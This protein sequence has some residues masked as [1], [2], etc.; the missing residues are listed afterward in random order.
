MKKQSI[1]RIF[2]LLTILSMLIASQTPAFAAAPGQTTGTT[3]SIHIATTALRTVAPTSIHVDDVI[4]YAIDLQNL[5][6]GGLSSAEFSCRYD[7]TLVDISNLRDVGLF[8]ATPV[9][10]INGPDAGTFVFAIA[11]TSGKATSSGTVF[12]LDLTAKAAGSFTFDCQVR[13]STGGALFAIAF[14]P[15]TITITVGDPAGSGNVTGIITASKAITV[16]LLTGDVVVKTA[17]PASGVAFLINA[18]AGTYTIRARAAGFLTRTGTVVIASGSTTTKTTV[19]LMAG[20]I[21]LPQNG[22]IDA[23]DVSTIGMNYNWNTPTEA[24]LNND[25]IINVLDLQLLAPNFEKTYPA[26]W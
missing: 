25:G 20:D 5:P 7:E 11:A 13:A 17:S 6:S 12:N 4:T 23:N 16:E 14:S 19:A 24:D 1:F 10:A 3:A 15:L 8:V 9:V 26:A 21:A 22:I 2:G 18:P